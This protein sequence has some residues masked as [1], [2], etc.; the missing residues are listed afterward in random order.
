MQG[1]S[2][3]VFL[4]LCSGS[5]VGCGLW[6]VGCGLITLLNLLLSSAASSMGK[7]QEQP[8]RFRLTFA[9][10]DA[11]KRLMDDSQGTTRP[12]SDIMVCGVAA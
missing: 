1:E 6:V 9:A 3:H 7:D 5:P 11:P 4:V 10:G 12:I 8:F 2:G